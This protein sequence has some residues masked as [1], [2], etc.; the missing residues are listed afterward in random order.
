M[1]HQES[2]AQWYS[3]VCLAGLD[4]QP[5]V[6]ARGYN[7]DLFRIFEVSESATEPAEVDAG[8]NNLLPRHENGE[9]ISKN[10][11]ETK[12]NVHTPEI[13]NI[14]IIKPEICILV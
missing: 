10:V 13:R 2:T 8:D 9:S 1:K 3:P 6:T 11:M 7:V 4:C 14:L 12:K 5:Q